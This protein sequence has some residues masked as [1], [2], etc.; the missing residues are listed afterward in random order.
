MLRTQSTEK[1]PYAPEHRAAQRARVILD[2]TEEDVHVHEVAEGWARIDGEWLLWLS[3]DDDQWQS[4]P[5]RA[6]VMVEW[7]MDARTEPAF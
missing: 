6:V 1:R 5:S 3:D 7:L 2:F 4:W